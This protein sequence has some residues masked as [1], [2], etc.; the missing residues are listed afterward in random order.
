MINSKSILFLCAIGCLRLLFFQE[1]Y[2]KSIEQMRQEFHHPP[3]EFTQAPFWF[4]NDELKEDLILEQIEWMERNG[5]YGFTP[6]ARIG[7]AKETGY[8]TGRWFELVEFAVSEAAKRG[9]MVY[10]YDEGMYPSG[11]GHG[12]VVEGH[13][14]FA[15]Q[16]LRMEPR[17]IMGPGVID[18]SIELNED[19]RLVAQ[20]LLQPAGGQTFRR[21]GAIVVRPGSTSVKVPEGAWTL[22]TFI[23][24]PSRGV[25]RGVYWEEEDNQ[26]NAP[27]SADL[28][29]P[30][31][32]RRF[33][34]VTHERYYAVLSGHFG[35]TI[36]GF[37]TD[38]PSILGRRARS[39]L[40]PWTTGFLDRIHSILPYSFTSFLPFL[41]VK[42]DDGIETVIRGD[43]QYAV[44]EALNDSYYRQLS[45]WCAAHEVALTGH[46][47]GAG[48]IKPQIYFHEPGQDVVWR[49]VLPGET[50]LEGEQSTL[51][52]SASSAAL[53]LGRPVVINECYGA[54]GWQL[55]LDEM[56]WLAD[57]LFVRGTNR[58]F[59]HAFYY[60]VR[61]R[62]IDERPPD[63]A[64][65]NLWK[66]QYRMFSDYTNR[67]SWLMTGY[68]PE[69]SVAILATSSGTPWNAAKILFQNQIDFHYMDEYFLDR[70]GIGEG[71]FTVGKCR[72][73]VLILDT[74][75]Y[76]TTDDV[77]RLLE[78]LNAGVR[79]I[80]YRTELHYHPLHKASSDE[81]IE[82]VYRHKN[83]IRAESPDQLIAE[84]IQRQTACI[85]T[86]R[87]VPDLRALY[88][89]KKDIEV[90]L[91]T[92]EGANDIDESIV[93]LKQ[94]TVP[95]IWN[96]ETGTT[97]VARAAKKHAEGIQLTVGIPPSTSTIVVFD[98]SS[99]D[100]PLESAGGATLESEEGQ[101][102]VRPVGPKWELS[103]SGRRYEL[104]DLASWTEWS[105]LEKF[106]GTG[107]YTTTFRL[108]G[109]DVKA[110]SIVLDL[111]RVESWA[112]VEVNGIDRG[113]RLWR[114]FRFDIGGAV[115]EG[116]NVI[117]I[118][119]T[120]TRANELTDKPLPSGLFGPVRL[121]IGSTADRVD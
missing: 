60:S 70:C 19:E 62:R 102:E 116:D 11:S 87:P 76:V 114:P 4:W 10:L 9:M 2:A 101:G 13:P 43:F 90:Y 77:N 3:R 67:M 119:V 45:E 42:A 58:L 79:L 40:R 111:G 117:R 56:K 61:E 68:R 32:V 94:T 82:R 31:A 22:F 6:H 115:N 30:A 20:V 109:D 86:T 72:Y 54:Y 78:L 106:S 80:S 100:Q 29:N 37:F 18:P 41:W 104:N 26:P 33:I 24:T 7:L 50:S 51:G 118:G 108:S 110:G 120:N 34:Q 27:K 25:I 44:D 14:E 92:N 97:A 73:R 91:L 98:R 17:E 107:W 21:D 121:V 84:L 74:D 57:W 93:F 64:W 35:T 36:R 1:S 95:E 28:L 96:A 38:E 112:R 65:F 66:D 89:H 113:T 63:L 81:W 105:E 15:S 47:A 59:P 52:K 83:F 39:G 75:H 71:S 8:M 49:W 12:A 69:T 88:F 16:G 85:S 5:V 99:Q 48:D 53:Q 55:T 46:P 23:Q 103:I